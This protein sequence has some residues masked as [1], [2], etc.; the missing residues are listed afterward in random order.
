MPGKKKDI[1]DILCDAIKKRRLTRFYYE[2]K[3]SG[4]YWRTVEPYI[5]AIKDNGAG[6]TFLAGLPVEELSKTIEARVMGHYLLNKLDIN[7]FELSKETYDEPHVPRDKI[8][9][10]P[11]I[12][13]ICRYY[14][15]DE[16]KKRK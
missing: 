5:L 12:K 15:P 6:N 2:S 11:T 14:Y 13:V 7:A 10:T 4:N 3:S 16:R 9:N 8:V 1:S